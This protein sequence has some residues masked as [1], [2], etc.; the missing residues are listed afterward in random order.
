MYFQ[1]TCPI[2]IVI[3]INLTIITITT[4]TNTIEV[5]SQPTLSSSK[6]TSYR[7]GKSFI[8]DLVENGT[9]HLIPGKLLINLLD[10]LTKGL[11]S[12]IINNMKDQ[13]MDKAS[14]AGLSSLDLLRLVEKQSKGLISSTL[15]DLNESDL[16]TRWNQV[17]QENHLDHYYWTVKVNKN[18]DN[19]RAGPDSM[20]GWT[21]GS[22]KR[23]ARS[24]QGSEE[25]AG[26]P[27]KRN[28]DEIDRQ[29]FAGFAGKRNFDEIDRQAFTG[30]TGKR[31]FDEIDRS[32]LTGFRGRRNFD[33][34][35]RSSFSGFGSGKRTGQYYIRQL[36][37]SGY[38]L[39][40]VGLTT[41]LHKDDKKNF[42]EID[43]QAFTGF[44]GRRNFDEID[45]SGFTGFYKRNFDEIDNSG[46]TGFVGKR[47]FDEIDRSAFNGFAKRPVVPS[48]QA[49]S[50]KESKA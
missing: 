23:S 33:E 45:S 29:A 6:P 43:R 44:R 13:S 10:P 3:V 31:N 42:D 16:I 40:P 1:Y 49:K 37:P 26:Q 22:S 50:V 12:Q 2:M 34:I 24:V 4:A 39:Y 30:F 27:E 32:G 8:D 21:V 18:D 20:S 25:F 15:N 9:L 48:N 5:T 41:N 36:T 38:Y 7:T 46:F 28:F 17:K 19:K 14:L 11:I 47:N 35:D